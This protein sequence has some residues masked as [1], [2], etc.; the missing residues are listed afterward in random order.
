M[1]QDRGQAVQGVYQAGDSPDQGP[2][3]GAHRGGGRMDRVLQSLAQES[4][5]NPFS[6][7]LIVQQIL[8]T[9]GFH[10]SANDRVF[11]F[12]AYVQLNELRN[13]ICLSN[14]LS[15]DLSL[16]SEVCNLLNLK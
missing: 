1:G 6:F 13:F 2:H 15:S 8:V 10:Y 12:K 3:V 4:K 9:C 14:L 7:Y 5:I 11:S 16:H